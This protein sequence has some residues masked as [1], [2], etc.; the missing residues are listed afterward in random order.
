M[1]H[2]DDDDGGGED[3]DDDM[4]VADILHFSLS[5]KA[6]KGANVSF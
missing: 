3:N 6:Q 2:Y 1:L 4:M 5:N